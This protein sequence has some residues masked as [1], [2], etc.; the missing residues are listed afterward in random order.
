M[1]AA[2]GTNTNFAAMP[3][4]TAFVEGAERRILRYVLQASARELLTKDERLGKCLRCPRTKDGGVQ[5]FRS[6]EHGSAHYGNLV[7]CARHWVCP[8]CAVKIASRRVVEVERA[9]S[10]VQHFGG[11]AGFLTLTFPHYF[12]QAVGPML[13][14]FLRSVRALKAHR[15]YKELMGDLGAFGE[16]RSLE[17]THGKNGWHPHTHSIHLFPSQMAWW[18]VQRVLRPLWASVALRHGLGA[19]S[20]SHGVVFE[21]VLT[22]G[23]S[24]ERLARYHI[25]WDAS[26]ELVRGNSKQ[27]RSGGRTPFALLAD[28]AMKDDA[29]AGALFVQYAAAFRGKNH[30]AWSR[31]L[32]QDFASA[33]NLPVAPASDYELAVAQDDDADLLGTISRAQWKAIL[34]VPSAR[35]ELLEVARAGDWS[36]VVQFI[37][38][39]T[40]GVVFDF[41]GVSC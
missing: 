31:G 34:R 40:R 16:I 32:R 10:A 1:T 3:S 37:D 35:G 11:S 8:V 26:D 19:V 30:I 28:Y 41:A 15:R 6:R 7:V 27:A 14:R 29:A 20:D 9:V 12:G 33:A 24:A 25:K 13:E 36:Q 17:V 4:S 38:G 21:H 5:V 18:D 23:E 22:G 39:F 2:L